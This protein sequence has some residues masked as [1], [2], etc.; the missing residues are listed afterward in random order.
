MNTKHNCGKGYFSGFV[1]DTGDAIG[2]IVV[3]YQIALKVPSM[4]ALA[5]GVC[6]IVASMVLESF[7]RKARR[8]ECVN[9]SANTSTGPVS[10]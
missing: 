9:K 2:G 8:R 1:R 6:L 5:I 4:G 10:L 3:G 7:D